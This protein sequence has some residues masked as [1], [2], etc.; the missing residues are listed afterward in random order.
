MA[1]QP[2][3]GPAPASSAGLC[4]PKVTG[5]SGLVKVHLSF[6]VELLGLD[7][8]QHWTVSTH[9]NEG[10]KTLTSCSS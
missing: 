3:T 8:L 5:E 4:E 7:A 10:Q 2:C 9:R 6:L 1:P